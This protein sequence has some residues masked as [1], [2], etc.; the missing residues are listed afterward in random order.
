M[1]CRRA[2]LSG[3]GTS[4][5]RC[6]DAIEACSNRNEVKGDDLTTRVA[7]ETSDDSTVLNGKYGS[8][9]DESR[10]GPRKSA[11]S[12]GELGLNGLLTRRSKDD[13]CF[14]RVGRDQSIVDQETSV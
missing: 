12:N 2:G 4:C 13:R 1:S 8:T 6:S 14:T 5:G 9:T 3:G 7:V 10:V 11:T